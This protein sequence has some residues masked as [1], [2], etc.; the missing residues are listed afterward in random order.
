VRSAG[1]LRSRKRPGTPSP[2]A[3]GSRPSGHVLATPAPQA[4]EGEGNAVGWA[5]RGATSELAPYKF[6]RRDCGAQD[7]S[8]KITHAG[9][10]H[11]DIH[12]VRGEWGPA[13]WPLI[14]G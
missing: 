2:S 11:S 13:Q 3:Q 5:S 8:I 9:I 7:V 6:T 1:S 12:T 4:V 14:P 10:C